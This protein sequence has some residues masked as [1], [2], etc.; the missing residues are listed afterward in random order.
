MSKLF[1]QHRDDIGTAM[2]GLCDAIGKLATIRDAAVAALDKPGCSGEDERVALA[3]SRACTH[4]T[5]AAADL[6]QELWQALEVE[7]VTAGAPEA[8]TRFHSVVHQCIG[9]RFYNRIGVPA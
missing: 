2:R 9:R 7:A 8:I 5:H 1:D 6:P 4:L 3:L